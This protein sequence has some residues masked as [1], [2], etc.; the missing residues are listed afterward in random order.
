VDER[1]NELGG[2]GDSR[3]SLTPAA[4][5]LLTRFLLLRNRRMD[6]VVAEC[7]ESLGGQ[8]PKG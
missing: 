8:A 4:R 6:A 7:E 5:E 3:S 1:A 2:K